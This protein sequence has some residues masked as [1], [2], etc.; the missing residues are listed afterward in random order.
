M[1]LDHSLCPV[2]RTILSPDL[3]M[4][5]RYDDIKRWIFGKSQTNKL[6]CNPRL[7][8]KHYVSDSNGSILNSEASFLIP[9][10]YK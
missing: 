8:L 9:E 4:M 2:V 10:P 1:P 5:E 6:R 7:G 3:V